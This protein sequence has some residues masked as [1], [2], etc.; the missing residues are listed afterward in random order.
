VILFEH[1]ALYGVEGEL[2][3]QRQS[4][5]VWHSLLRRSGRDLTLV[6]YGGTLPKAL[7]AA[8]ALAKDGIEAEVI[9][10]RCLRPLD[11]TPVFASVARTHRVL[12]CDEGWMTGS[13]AG[14]IIA[15]IAQ[16][17]FY[18]LDAPPARVC[19]I[20]VPVPYAAHMERA[21]LPQADKIAHAARELVRGA[22]D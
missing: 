6:S 16:R 5:D 15:Q 1:Q 19:S 20:E 8:E 22:H 18:D 2:D 17:A 7:L 3:E 14:E 4:P 9:D 21:A 12:V 10:L 13:L 11:L